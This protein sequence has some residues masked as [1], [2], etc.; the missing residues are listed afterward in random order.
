MLDGSGL[1]EEMSLTFHLC[2]VDVV[3]VVFI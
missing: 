2:W 3:F 1:G